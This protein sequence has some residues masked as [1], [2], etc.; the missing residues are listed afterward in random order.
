MDYAPLA[1]IIVR[2][3]VG[4]VLG[5]D[6]SGLLVGDADVITMVALAIGFVVEVVYAIAKKKG[7]ST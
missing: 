6:A 4:A 5:A 2:Y 7:W 3:A 1:R